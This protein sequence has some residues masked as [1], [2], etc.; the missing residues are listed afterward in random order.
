MPSVCKSESL[1]SSL[2]SK[3]NDKLP[4]D[5]HCIIIYVQLEQRV[6]YKSIGFLNCISG[7]GQ[8]RVSLCLLTKDKKNTINKTTMEMYLE[9]CMYAYQLRRNIYTH[10]KTNIKSIQFNL[11]CSVSLDRRSSNPEIQFTEFSLICLSNLNNTVLKP[12]TSPVNEEL[13]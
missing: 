4:K 8:G 7:S 10:E 13:C 3:E 9:D 5:K 6:L 2:C 11:F 12:F 1:C